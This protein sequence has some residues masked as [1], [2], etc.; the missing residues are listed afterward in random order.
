MFVALPAWHGLGTVLDAPPSVRDALGLAG[1]NWE[2]ELS[3]L[4]LMGTS[5]EVDAMATRRTSDGAVLGVVG[6]GYRP[7]QNRTAFEF[8]EP[9]VEAG[10]VQIE[11]AGSLRGGKHVW[12]LCKISDSSAEIVRGDHV[13]QYVLLSN[14]HDG[15]RAVSVGYTA[16]RVVCQNTLTA[17]LRKG[18]GRHIR[19]KHTRNA[20]TALSTLRETMDVQRR[21]FRATADA[22]R[23]LA[24]YGCNERDLR[25]YVNLVFRS[26]SDSLAAEDMAARALGERE[27]AAS[28]AE[29][30]SKPARMG[31]EKQD[32]L[33]ERVRP[34][35]DNGRGQALPGV[36]GTYWAAYN[37]VTEYLTHE[38][39]GDADTR[40][41][42]LWMGEGRELGQ[43]ALDVA[44]QMCAR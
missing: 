26:K 11:A 38:R 2:V 13:E 37:A 15:S 43:R 28:F 35:F 14:S 33:Y 20:E 8:F 3:H 29:L 6:K 30:I 42:Q 10:D 17:A 34:L 36:P 44:V 1:L 41:H 23:L 16:V 22:F 31:T 25:E 4:S 24:S 5:I 40:M 7:V 18:G 32:R 27:G 12:V 9:L 39:G 19:I 21:E